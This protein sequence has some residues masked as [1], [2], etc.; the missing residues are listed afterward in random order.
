MSGVDVKTS[1]NYGDSGM[2]NRSSVKSGRRNVP[3]SLCI[4]LHFSDGNSEMVRDP[5]QAHI[6]DDAPRC[7]LRIEELD[8]EVDTL[9]NEISNA[10]PSR[11]SKIESVL[12]GKEISP[13]SITKV[14]SVKYLMERE[15]SSTSGINVNAPPCELDFVEGRITRCKISDSFKGC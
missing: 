3:F 11:P 12:G 1:G 13:M 9:M 7:D 5:A 14:E 4:K 8:D 6:R 10:S 2:G 15:A